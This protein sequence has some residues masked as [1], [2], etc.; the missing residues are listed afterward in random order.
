M[1]KSY[2]I[3][4]YDLVRVIAVILVVIS[5]CTYYQITTQYGGINYAPNYA[6]DTNFMDE[7]TIKFLTLCKNI[8]YTFHMPVF[9]ALSGALFK[10]SIKKGKINKLKDILIQ[11]AKRLLIP[12]IIIVVLFST[13][14]KYLSGYFNNSENL[15]K[16]IFV[17]QILLQGN[18]YLWFLPTLFFEF[19]IIGA[20]KGK[21]N[22]KKE[23]K[24]FF[25][26]FM[27]LNLLNPLIKLTIVKNIFYYL[28]YFYIGYCF[29]DNRIE[30]NQR[31]DK[32][33][34]FNIVLKVISII[35]LLIAFNVYDFKQ[36][37]ILKIVKHIL[38]LFM[39]IIGTYMIY[40]IAY[41]LSKTNLS[42]NT[43]IQK[44]SECSFGIYL[45][46]DPLNYLILYIT[47]NSFGIDGF[48]T[49]PGI[50]FIF[51]A[52]V[53]ITFF[54]A[55]AMTSLLRKKKIKYIC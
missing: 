25:I 24:L 28:I 47:Y 8:L 20:I 7:I 42:K 50:I 55:F 17:G 44:I 48:Y 11:K 19:L 51:F 40:L 36:N 2:K 3:E 15:L 34:L 54:T 1:S 22:N 26:I 41:K 30:T 45:Y 4:E 13:P 14:I 18:N 37:S 53:C 12:F 21:I 9:F 33:S 5:H 16:D 49:N 6:L 23:K 10:N 31:I 38:E 43:R 32:K 52:R 46:S 27:L 29:E 35:I 39:G